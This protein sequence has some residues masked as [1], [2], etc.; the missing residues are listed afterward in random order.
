MNFQLSEQDVLGTS[1]LPHSE[2]I[3]QGAELLC[4]LIDTK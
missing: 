3:L 4:L 2:T 1:S